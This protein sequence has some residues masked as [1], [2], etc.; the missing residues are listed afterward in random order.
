MIISNKPKTF[1]ISV[2]KEIAGLVGFCLVGGVCV[3][4]GVCV[5]F[6]LFLY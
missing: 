1:W 5:L 2:P 4:R 6:C 3:W